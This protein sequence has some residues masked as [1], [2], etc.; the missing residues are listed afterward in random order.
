MITLSLSFFYWPHKWVRKE[1]KPSLDCTEN[2]EYLLV[3]T[4]SNFFVSR[5]N[6]SN[7]SSIRCWLPSSPGARCSPSDSQLRLQQKWAV[8]EKTRSK[9]VYFSAVFVVV[10]KKDWRLFPCNSLL[11][12]LWLSHVLCTQ[13]VCE[14]GCV[15]FWVL[16]RLRKG[17]GR[18][19]CICL[20][21]RQKWGYIFKIRR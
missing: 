2:H 10:V 1:G 3:E 6:S 7:W 15:F 9:A 18:E 4:W 13:P 20:H 16:R 5:Q 19:I 17:D 8:L 21:L 12:W 14:G 11:M